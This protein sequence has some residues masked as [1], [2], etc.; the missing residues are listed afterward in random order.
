MKNEIQKIL[1][2]PNSGK[3]WWQHDVQLCGHSSFTTYLIPYVVL[4]K[5][6][7]VMARK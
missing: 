2:I 7:G 1:R 3:W 4:L 6:E 5:A